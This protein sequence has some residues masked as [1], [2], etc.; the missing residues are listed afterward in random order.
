MFTHQP[1][2]L[3]S[4]FAECWQK[5]RGSKLAFFLPF[6]TLI[7]LQLL[8]MLLT[9]ELASLPSWLNF[10]ISLILPII[11]T[12]P[13][14]AGLGMVGVKHLRQEPLSW[15]SGFQYYRIVP[16][17]F[18][19][20]LISV[21]LVWLILMIIGFAGILLMRLLHVDFHFQLHFGPVLSVAIIILALILMCAK[22]LLLFNLLLVA[23]QGGSPLTAW[24]SSIKMVWPHFGKVLLAVIL[25]SLI[26]LA[27][28]ILVGVGLIWTIPFAFLVI[29][30]LYLLCQEH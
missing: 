13:L 17:L 20:Y 21:I 22:T 24:W 14:L 29:A 6:F 11:L 3:K 7:V 5:V 18:I 30:K 1:I 16:Q 15:S 12:T 27:G 19:A 4:V 26:N 9:R 2:H 23:D 8:L 25:F 10:I 28:L